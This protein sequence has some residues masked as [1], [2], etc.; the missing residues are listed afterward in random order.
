MIYK[1]NSLW[2][3][4]LPTFNNQEPRSLESFQEDE[5][6]VDE[7]FLTCS[8]SLIDEIQS[9]TITDNY[10]S[11]PTKYK[12]DKDDLDTLNKVKE[13]KRISE[14]YQDYDLFP[15]EL[16][17]DSFSQGKIGDCYF[18][19][20]ISLISNYGELLTRLFPIKKNVHGYY[21]VILFINGWKRVIIDD[22]I[23]TI[24]SE[25]IGCTSQEYQKCF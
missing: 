1:D 7:Q 13:W 14:L 9:K 3:Q 4:S 21:E 24:N 20:M 15:P 17:C 5:K 25:T 11:N 2:Y 23:P 12:D 8:D 10:I 18:V 6:Y 19:N 22:Y 16:H